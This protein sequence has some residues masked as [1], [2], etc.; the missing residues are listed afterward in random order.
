MKQRIKIILIALI[1]MLF[2]ISC[3]KKIIEEKEE[4][5]TEISE[6]ISGVDTLEE[7]LDISELENLEKD[8]DAIDW[9]E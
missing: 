6:D 7:D 2:I 4:A 5:E 9:E 8:L 3:A 1:A